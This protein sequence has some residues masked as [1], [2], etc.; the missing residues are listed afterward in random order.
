M[1]KTDSNTKIVKINYRILKRSEELMFHRLTLQIIDN[2]CG[3]ATGVLLEQYR[4]ACNVFASLMHDKAF[5][6]SMS[7]N[8]YDIAADAAWTSLNAQAQASTL[9]P[10]DEVREAGQKV[11]DVINLHGNPI[12]LS[13]NEEYG[14]LGT[15]IAQLRTLGN[16][17]LEKAL[18]KPHFDKLVESYNLFMLASEAKADNKSKQAAGQ[19]KESSEQCY[20]CWKRLAQYLEAM[21]NANALPGAHDA[22]ARINVVLTPVKT[23]L[24]ARKASKIDD[25][26]NVFDA[27]SES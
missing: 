26:E 14:V 19:M 16:D 2:C 4:D 25:S 1:A 17:I 3:T 15:L 8:D 11:A 27:S 12:H 23:R 9:H 6:P 5:V 18:V 13:Y 22:I 21:G 10:Y 20:A 24:V 7:L